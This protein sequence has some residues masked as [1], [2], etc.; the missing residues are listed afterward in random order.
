MSHVLARVSVCVD[1]SLRY[2]RDNE[3]EERKPA[4]L[5]AGS[6]KRRNVNLKLHFHIYMNLGKRGIYK[7]TARSCSSCVLLLQRLFC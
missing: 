4:Y 2:L 3:Y 6:P 7:S 1:T 5:I